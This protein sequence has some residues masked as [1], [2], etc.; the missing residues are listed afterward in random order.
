MTFNNWLVEIENFFTSRKIYKKA[1]K[2]KLKN[3]HEGQ[4]LKNYYQ[5]TWARRIQNSCRT[6]YVIKGFRRKYTK[7]AAIFLM[8]YKCGF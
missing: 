5:E 2:E 7:I 8:L 6:I 4:H 1:I 3:L